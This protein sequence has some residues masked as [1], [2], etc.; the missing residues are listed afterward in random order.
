MS[1]QKSSPAGTSYLPQGDALIVKMFDG[2]IVPTE[3]RGGTTR[4]ANGLEVALS[5]DAD[6][7]L[8]MAVVFFATNWLPKGTLGS[9]SQ[10]HNLR[11]LTVAG[12]D[13]TM[14]LEL[15]PGAAATF[16][17][18]EGIEVEGFELHAALSSYG[19]LIGFILPNA[20]RSLPD[21][22]ARSPRRWA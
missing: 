14:F 8:F 6:R 4:F 11:L 5:L 19:R 10:P 7:R 22:Y 15:V 3:S 9:M 1:T 21:P 20:P 18:N 17:S 2:D 12:E 16:A 13:D